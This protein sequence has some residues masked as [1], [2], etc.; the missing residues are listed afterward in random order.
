[1]KTWMEVTSAMAN[2][3]M[4]GSDVGKAFRLPGF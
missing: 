2:G 3:D 4:D 1:M